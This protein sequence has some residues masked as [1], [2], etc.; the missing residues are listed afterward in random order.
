[1]PTESKKLQSLADA[2]LRSLDQLD[3]DTP[4]VEAVRGHVLALAQLLG[5]HPNVLGHEAAERVRDE[6]IMEGRADDAIRRVRGFKPTTV[7]PKRD[8][9]PAPE[10]LVGTRPGLSTERR[11][12][13]MQA[14]VTLK[15]VA[16]AAGTSYTTTRMY[17]SKRTS[18][19]PDKREALDQV[20]AKFQGERH[21]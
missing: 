2:I 8:T 14:G 16:E 4:Q 15:Q 20:Y 17:E 9:L 18:V 10:P 6:R 13:R 3:G 1:M 19:R 12:Q 21:K 7:P 11:L 5:A